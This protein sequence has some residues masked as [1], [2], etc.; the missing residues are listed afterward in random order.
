M[1]SFIKRCYRHISYYHWSSPMIT[2]FKSKSWFY[3]WY[4][5]ENKICLKIQW[6][7][8]AI[9]YNYWQVPY[10]LSVTNY[11]NRF[12][13]KNNYFY[14]INNKWKQKSNTQFK[15]I[16]IAK[17]VGSITRSIKWKGTPKSNIY[18]D[19]CWWYYYS[20]IH[21]LRVYWTIISIHLSFTF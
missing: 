17:E 19:Q 12:L 16:D 18:L 20:W 15:S 10:R 5:Y 7:I 4:N 6:C 1:I 2:H 21:L 14:A 8:A 11:N 13:G 9:Q 3:L